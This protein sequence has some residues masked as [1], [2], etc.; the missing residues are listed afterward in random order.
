MASKNQQMGN[1]KGKHQ[2]AQRAASAP[3]DEEF[4]SDPLP[5]PPEK[6][7]S[8]F[9]DANYQL[10]AEQ[11]SVIQELKLKKVA[12]S[13]AGYHVTFQQMHQ[14]VAVEGAT[15]SVHMIKD[16]RVQATS[17]ALES[18]VTQLDVQRM[19]QDSIDQHEAM[20]IAV[21]NAA[22]VGAA[23]TPTLVERVILP[24]PEPRLAWKVLLLNADTAQEWVTWIDAHTGEVLQHQEISAG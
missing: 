10:V 24:Q 1:L 14:G 7:A 9:L 3:G 21:Q 11:R 23:A 12:R 6:A 2:R 19:A 13:P 20:Q 15:V 18:E 17:G 8:Q 16:Q 4:L 22:S 5:G